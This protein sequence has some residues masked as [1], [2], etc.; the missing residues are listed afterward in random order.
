MD[1][2]KISIE[3]NEISEKL[4]ALHSNKEKELTPI[5]HSLKPKFK[6]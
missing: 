5:E 3:I 2:E 1:L 6:P 4:V